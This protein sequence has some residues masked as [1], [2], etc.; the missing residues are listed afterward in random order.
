[1]PINS[2]LS[3]GKELTDLSDNVT[4]TAD[5][6]RDKR[7]VFDPAKNPLKGSIFDVAETPDE[8]AG[9]I[10]YFAYVGGHADDLPR[11]EDMRVQ[12]LLAL[13]RTD[14]NCDNTESRYR[15]RIS[16]PLSGIR[17]WCVTQC[18]H[19]SVKAVTNCVSV[20]CPLWAF[21]MG[22]NGMRGKQ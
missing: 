15:T 21:R 11:G 3:Q 19:G 16:G 9:I 5:R 14:R 10:G 18:Q 2:R 20:S 17:A 6:A 7:G 8:R 4:T 12:D 13:V 22:T 1:M